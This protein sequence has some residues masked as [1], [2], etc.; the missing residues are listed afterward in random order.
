MG[1]RCLA[2]LEIPARQRQC[3]MRVGAHLEPEFRRVVGEGLEM[4]RDQFVVA[5]RRP[6]APLTGLRHTADAHARRV[7]AG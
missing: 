5:R 7:R 6:V 2:D 4:P 1:P 3:P